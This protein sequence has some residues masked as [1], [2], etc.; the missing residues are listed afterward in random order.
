MVSQERSGMSG[1]RTAEGTGEPVAVIGVGL[2]LPGGITTLG[3]L[4]A[5]LAG[6]EDLVTS[7]PGD[8]FSTDDFVIDGGGVRPGKAYTGAAGIFGDVWGF[9]PEYFGISPKE[10]A[11]IDPQQRLLL[12]CAVEAF[13]DGGV[14]PRLLAGSDVAVVMGLTVQ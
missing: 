2:R 5:A 4:W 13:D 8:R 7:V 3:G 6:G 11:Q 9:D 12:E 10:A 14:D 1:A